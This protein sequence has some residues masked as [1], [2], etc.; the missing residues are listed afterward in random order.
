MSDTPSKKQPYVAPRLTELGRVEDLTQGEGW[1]SI[2]D[3][4]NYG[5]SDI[6]GKPGGGGG[7]G[8]G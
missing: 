8:S 2:E 3:F 4:F 6:F 1:W 5:F 7:L